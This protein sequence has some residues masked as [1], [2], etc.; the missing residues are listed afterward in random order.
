MRTL[1]LSFCV[2]AF[3][4]VATAQTGAPDRITINASKIETPSETQMVAHGGV[5][6]QIGSTAT[7]TADDVTLDKGKPGQLS[8]LHLSGNVT[9]KAD[10]NSP[11][12]R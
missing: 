3:A 8:E 4:L 9:M 1:L 7:I 5:T 10:F 12:R 2:L 11:N 6:I